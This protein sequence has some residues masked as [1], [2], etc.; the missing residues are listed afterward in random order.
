MLG[1]ETLRL[2]RVET[3]ISMHPGISNSVAGWIMLKCLHIKRSVIYI[4]PKL[5][6]LARKHG[7]YLRKIKT[8]IINRMSN[9][10]G[11]NQPK[12]ISG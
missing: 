7:L 5:K 6:S 3:V 9:V 11:A 2:T 8:N 10:Q 1:K 12:E 4:K